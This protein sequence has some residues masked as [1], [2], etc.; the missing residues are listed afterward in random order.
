VQEECC[1]VI[2]GRY[3]HF[4][5]GSWHKSRASRLSRPFS[6]DL[7]PGLKT[8][9]YVLTDCN[10]HSTTQTNTLL[11]MAHMSRAQFMTI[12]HKS[13]RSLRLAALLINSRFQQCCIFSTCYSCRSFGG[14][15]CILSS[16]E[17]FKDYSW[18]PR[19]IQKDLSVPVNLALWCCL[20]SGS[21]L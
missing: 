17:Q 18:K 15:Q 21:E 7:N 4:L 20:C 8:G 16:T 6:R 2:Q 1:V 11:S 5:I 19:N 9:S 14:A 13:I 10:V 12:R 3:C